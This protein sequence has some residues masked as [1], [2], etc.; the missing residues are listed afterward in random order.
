MWLLMSFGWFLWCP[1]WLPG[2][3][4]IIAKVLWVVAM[5]FFYGW[6]PGCCYVAVRVSGFCSVVV[7]LLY[8]HGAGNTKVMGLIPRS[9]MD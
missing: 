9:C 8:L 2:H 7:A 1:E 6:L 5:V 3:C 4:Y